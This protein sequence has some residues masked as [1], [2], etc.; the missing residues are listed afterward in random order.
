LKKYVILSSKLRRNPVFG[1]CPISRNATPFHP[2]VW[3]VVMKSPANCHEAIIG[4]SGTSL[5]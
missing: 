5:S 3:R 1:L 4:P 2:T